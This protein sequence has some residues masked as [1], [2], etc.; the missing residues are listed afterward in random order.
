MSKLFLLFSLVFVLA[1]CTDEPEMTEPDQTEIEEAEN[2][3]ES[4]TVEDSEREEALAYEDIGYELVDDSEYIEELT[5]VE[6]EIR[7]QW[8]ADTYTEESPLVVLNPY[9]IAPLS[10]LVMFETEE[11]SLVTYGVEG[12]TEETTF[13]NTTDELATTHELPIFGLYPGRINTIQ[14]ELED[15]EGNVSEHQVQ[16]ETEEIPEGFYDLKLVESQP[17]RM[18]PG[19]TFLNSSAAE[20]TAVDSQGEIR[21]MLKPWMANS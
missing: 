4:E 5:V 9:G 10:A 20:Y 13:T 3:T 2:T 8:E 6:D 1:A 18:H 19:V 16:V 14:F 11:A 7:E 17:D 15:E 21:F 12:D